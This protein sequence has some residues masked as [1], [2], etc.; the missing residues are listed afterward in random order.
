M[1]ISMNF[2][3]IIYRLICINASL[4]TAFSDTMRVDF[5]WVFECK[6]GRHTYFFPITVTP[7]TN[8]DEQW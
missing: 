1:L 8:Y 7:C 5:V 2:K 6:L 3:R 4:A